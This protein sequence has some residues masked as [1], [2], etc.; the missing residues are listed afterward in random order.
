MIP[1]DLIK[2]DIDGGYISRRKHPEADLWI[3]NYSHKTQIEGAWNSASILCRGLIVDSEWNVVERP[4]LKF[5]NL[6]QWAAISDKT[7]L[8]YGVPYKNLFDGPFEIT[9]KA[10]G[11]LGILYYDGKD[12]AIATRGSFTSEQA[13]KGTEI[14][15]EKYGEIYPDITRTYLFEIVYPENRIVCRYD[16]EELIL[17]AIIDKRTGRDISVDSDPLHLIFP[18]ARRFN[19]ENWRDLPQRD[20]AEGYVIRFLNSDVRVKIKF[21]EYLRLHRIRCSLENEDRILQEVLT[22]DN[23]F[24]K[25]P[26]I[27]DEIHREVN[28]IQLIVDSWYNKLEAECKD[29]VKID[30]GLSRKEFALKY[31]GYPNRSILFS[32]LDGKDYRKLLLKRIGEELCKK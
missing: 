6:N 12:W 10:D 13:I 9:E 19:Y 32:M 1:I 4:F 24:E 31:Q 5:F 7:E 29:I 28:R 2:Q 17:L 22:G 26:E 25:F 30:G 18:C 8:L 14:L 27:P 23:I 11:S 20:N 21:D 16:F 15:R 3:L